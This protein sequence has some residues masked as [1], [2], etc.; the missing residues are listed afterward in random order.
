MQRKV[1]ILFTWFILTYTY[2]HLHYINKLHC[3]MSLWYGKIS[4]FIPEASS[5]T[6]PCHM[7]EGKQ[8]S[9]ELMSTAVWMVRCCGCAHLGHLHHLLTPQFTPG[10]VPNRL[11]GPAIS[12]SDGVHTLQCGTSGLCFDYCFSEDP[13]PHSSNSSRKPGLFR[14]GWHRADSLVLW[15]PSQVS[16]TPLV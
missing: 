3:C 12:Q 2:T 9:R 16:W 4:K 11:P 14:Q 8:H 15:E 7:I 1:L 10:K 6:S 5:Q 13:T